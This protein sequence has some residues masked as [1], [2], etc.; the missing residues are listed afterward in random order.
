MNLSGNFIQISVENLDDKEFTINDR[1]QVIKII[2]R[3]GYGSVW[4]A[5]DKY[6]N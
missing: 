4:H 3:G 6:T 5:L 1:F 2:G